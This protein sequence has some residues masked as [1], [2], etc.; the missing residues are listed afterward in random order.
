MRLVSVIGLQT[1]CSRLVFVMLSSF[2]NVGLLLEK[3]KKGKVGMLVIILNGKYSAFLCSF[4]EQ[5][6]I[7]LV[8]HT[9]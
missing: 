3:T 4:C 7:R 1:K 6:K 5:L 9:F 2:Q 8:W